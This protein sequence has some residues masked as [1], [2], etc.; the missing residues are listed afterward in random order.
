MDSRRRVA[1]ALLSRARYLPWP[2]WMRMGGEP[3]QSARGGEVRGF[4]GSALARKP[5]TACNTGAGVTQLVGKVFRY[6]G[7]SAGGSV[8]GLMTRRLVIFEKTAGLRSRWRRAAERARYP[9]A[10]Q[11]A[12]HTSAKCSVTQAIPPG[13][14][15][16]VAFKRISHA[17]SDSSCVFNRGS[18]NQSFDASREGGGLFFRASP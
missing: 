2:H 8:P 6:A 1:K 15:A 16:P 4:Y 3:L 7:A 14:S 12:T 5:S 13:T 17:E 9:P 18:Q 11:P 10:E